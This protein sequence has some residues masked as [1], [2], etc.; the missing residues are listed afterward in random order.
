MRDALV[1]VLSSSGFLA[2]RLMVS[3][4]CVAIVARDH[5][6]ANSGMGRLM[7]VVWILT[8][9]S[10]CRISNRFAANDRFGSSLSSRA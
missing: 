9:S 3:L 8:A 4:A 1:P 10:A 6:R 5:F 7:K 2:A